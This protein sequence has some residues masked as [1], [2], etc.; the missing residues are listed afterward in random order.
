MKRNA[1]PWGIYA[2]VFLLM[3]VVS[4]GVYYYGGG[5]RPAPEQTV[6]PATRPHPPSAQ[7]AEKGVRIEGGEV[8]EKDEQGR[9]LW[10]VRADGKI[11]YDDKTNVLRGSD[12]EFEVARQ[13]QPAVKVQATDFVADYAGRRIEFANGVGAVLTDQSGDFQ[14][15]KLEYHMTTQKLIGTGGVKLR[16][17]AYVASADRL[18]VDIKNGQTRLHG[19]VLL[20]RRL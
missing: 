3:A 5:G 18:V 8:V 20:A 4:V 19:D 10:R 1:S 6:G 9:M 16:H 17:G 12:I 15:E 7:P 13:G 2:A 11:T 14:V